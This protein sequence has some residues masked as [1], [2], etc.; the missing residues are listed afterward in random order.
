VRV[1]ALVL[2]AAGVLVSL[3][4]AYAATPPPKNTSPPT[5][6]GTPQ[7]GQKLTAGTGSWTGKPTR[8][9]YQWQRCDSSG[10]NCNPISG[11]TSSTYTPT[12]SD[13]G[14]TLKVKVTATNSG[15]SG[16]ASS[17]PTAVVQATAIAPT[18]T[19]PPTITG[20]AQDGQ[21]LTAG[22]GSWNGAQPITYTYQWQRCDSTGNNCNPISGAT[23]STYTATSADVG[24]T[25][26]VKVT[27]TN[28]VGSSSASSAATATV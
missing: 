24:N 17:A 2:V 12:S 13:V 19:A 21:L 7:V 28:S 11:A 1:G 5:I 8:Y 27:A 20:T 18:N 3:P 16:S 9:A 23:G 14:S 6:T 25:L 22:T 26:K 10:S 4:I 15:G